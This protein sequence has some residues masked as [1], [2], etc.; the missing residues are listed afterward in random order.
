MTRNDLIEV[1]A[2][3]A[4]AGPIVVN[5]SYRGGKGGQRTTSRFSVAK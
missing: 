5:L 4:G 3:L 2:A 1:Q